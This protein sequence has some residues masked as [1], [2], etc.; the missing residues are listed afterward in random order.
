MRN[1]RAGEVWAG[2]A[3]ARQAT[4]PQHAYILV[5]DAAEIVLPDGTRETIGTDVEVQWLYTPNLVVAD[6]AVDVGSHNWPSGSSFQHWEFDMDEAQRTAV[7]DG[8]GRVVLHGRV[9]LLQPRLAALL[10]I[11]PGATATHD[12]WRLILKDVQRTGDELALTLRSTMIEAGAESTFG[13]IERDNLA[14][15]PYQYTLATAERLDLQPIRS[16]GKSGASTWLV[17]P[18]PR[19]STYT[20]EL[21]TPP[22][23]RDESPRALGDDPKLAVIDW[24]VV[25][26]YRITSEI[27]NRDTTGR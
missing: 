8:S 23:Y 14:R 17:L 4:T 1:E 11:E 16:A 2:A 22:P 19:V 18:G 27:P 12:G 6:G 20:Q 9:H 15:G 7:R 3:L 13:W 21:E 10:P 26:T 24:D 25:A 5:V